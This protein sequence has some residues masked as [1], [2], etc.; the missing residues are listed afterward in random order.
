MDLPEFY[1]L[2]NHG[3]D[4]LVNTFVGNCEVIFVLLLSG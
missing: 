2:R 1:Y 3:F 4:H